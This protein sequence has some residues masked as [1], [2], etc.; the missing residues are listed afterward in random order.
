MRTPATCTDPPLFHPPHRARLTRGGETTTLGGM[1]DAPTCTDTGTAHVVICTTGG[2]IGAATRADGVVEAG[3]GLD[4][5]RSALDAAVPPGVRVTWREV[6]DRDSSAMGPVEFDRLAT[7]VTETLDDTGDPVDAVV[8][9]HGTDTLEESAMLL[10]L[11]HDDPRPV[12]VTGAQRAA[13]SPDADGPANLL[14][15]VLVAADPVSRDLG[16][17]V[18]FGRAVLQARGVRKWHTSDPVGFA[19]EAP[20]PETDVD[21]ETL[22]AGLARPVLGSGARASAVRVDTIAAFP[23][24][25]DSALRAAVAAGARGLVVEGLGSGNLPP[26]LADG[27]RDALA[28]DPDLVVVVTTRVPR[29]TVQPVYGGTGGG[30][31]LARAGVLF[32]GRLRSGQ[33]RVLLACLLDDRGPAATRR[34]WDTVARVGA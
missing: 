32:G 22:P 11:R 8:V 17:L 28:V 5:M 27:L 29:G 2:T 34:D 10:D 15:A 9:A 19:R 4:A 16:V 14:D 1:T 31:A 23:G 12:V 20:D 7:A 21:P 18:V 13:D 26:A 25:D 3:R 6:L 30:A 24:A 33:A